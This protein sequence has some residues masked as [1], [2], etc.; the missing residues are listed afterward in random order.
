MNRYAVER[1]WMKEGMGGWSLRRPWDRWKQT[2][3]KWEIVV[4]AF[5]PNLSLSFFLSPSLCCLQI[6][7]YCFMTGLR[8]KLKEKGLTGRFQTALV[9]I[10]GQKRPHCL[11]PLTC[12]VSRRRHLYQS[13]GIIGGAWWCEYGLG[14]SGRRREW[15]FGFWAFWNYCYW[16]HS[17]ICFAPHVKGLSLAYLSRTIVDVVVDDFLCE[18]FFIFL[19]SICMLARVHTF[20]FFQIAGILHEVPAYLVF[21]SFSLSHSLSLSGPWARVGL[22]WAISNC[23]ARPFLTCFFMLKWEAL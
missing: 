18:S 17:N 22:D 2:A 12:F 16:A 7:T 14:L 3:R 11:L 23:R 21:L 20:S 1:G 6:F 8:R 9:V 5:E 4:R 13:V 10:L 15:Y 19:Y